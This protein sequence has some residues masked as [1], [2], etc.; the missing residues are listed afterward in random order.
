MAK[1][2]GFGQ[3]YLNSILTDTAAYAGTELIRR[4]VGMAQVKDVTSIE[5]AN[6]RA[7]VEKV[8]ILCGKQYVIQRESFRTGADFVAAFEKALIQAKA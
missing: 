4:T 5:D 2:K 7:Y 3:Y 1:T 8:N 6:I